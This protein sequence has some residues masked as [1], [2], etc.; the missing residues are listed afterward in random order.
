MLAS[1]IIPAVVARLQA[2][3]LFGGRIDLAGNLAALMKTG[4]PMQPVLRAHV[5]PADLAG[6]EVHSATGGFIQSLDRGVSVLITLPAFDGTGAAGM[7][8]IEA[9]IASTVGALCGWAPPDTPGVFRLRQGRLLSLTG[10]VI[11]YQLDFT[12]SDQL[13][14]S[15]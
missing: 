15:P 3:G 12:I 5:L 4:Q 10:G 1:P 9:L 6:R 8:D 7:P 2:A 13:R 11:L 14:I